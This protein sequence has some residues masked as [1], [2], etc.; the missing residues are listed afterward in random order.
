MM[1]LN[2]GDRLPFVE[3]I[4]GDSHSFV[5]LD[6]WVGTELDIVNAARVS[7]HMESY[8]EEGGGLAPRDT[9]LIN[10]LLREKHGTPF[11]QGFMSAWHIRLPIFVMREWV[12]HRIG[13]SVNE[14]SG[15]YT[16]MRPDFYL[17]MEARKQTGKPGA[18]KFEL[19]PDLDGHLQDEVFWSATQGIEAY[20]RMLELG[21]AKEQARIILPLNL[22]TEMRWTANSRSLMNFLALRNSPHAMK[23]IRLYAEAIEGI[24]SQHMPTVYQAFV[25]NER[26]AP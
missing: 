17:P 12:R 8:L 4:L 23:E 15:R 11:E 9:G 10:Y 6:H 13:Y 2:L 7:F 19:A 3:E 5:K 20:K 24:F 25:D 22:Y 26:V 1:D 21:I 14:E 18:Y 16:E